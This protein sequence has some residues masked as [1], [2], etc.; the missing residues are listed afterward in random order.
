MQYRTLGKT[1]LHV[2]ALAFG[3]SSLGGVFREVDEEEAIR[4]VRVAL[5]HGINL[6]DTAP[7]YGDTRAE[8]VLGK[9]L[10]GI[11]RESYYLATKVGRYGPEVADFDFSA[12]RTK[13]SVE[14]SLARLGV[15]HV[16]FIQVHDMEFGH[17]EEIIQETLPALQRVRDA[18]KARFVGITCLPIPLFRRV[19]DQVEVDQIQSYCHYCLND[20]TLADLLPYLREKGVGIFNSA[21]LAMRLL[22]A[23]GPPAWHPAPALVREKCAEAARY[24]QQRSGN[25]G[26]LAL[27]YALANPD[28]HTHVV[29]TARPERVLENIRDAQEPPDEELLA[30]VLRTLQPVHNITWPSG[31]PENNPT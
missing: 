5:D 25:I 7:Y 14:E 2:S 1:G 11:P 22:S 24:C 30:G 27:Q 12:E 31:L 21:P 4:S 13:R 19:M 9:A 17:V 3:G 20:T 8:T 18:G 10:R 6:I 15:D 23:E 26:R 28:I 29:G 16:D